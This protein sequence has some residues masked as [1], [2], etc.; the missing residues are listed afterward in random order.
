M[1]KIPNITHKNQSVPA[2]ESLGVAAKEDLG[3]RQLIVNE[4]SSFSSNY[5]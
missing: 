5:P 3:T 2:E 4:R 1:H